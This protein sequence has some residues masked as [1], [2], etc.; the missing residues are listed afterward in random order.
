MRVSLIINIGKSETVI[1]K[2]GSLF[3]ALEYIEN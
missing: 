2:A 1:D 3:L